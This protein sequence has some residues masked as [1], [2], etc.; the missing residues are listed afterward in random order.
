[1]ESGD[2]KLSPMLTIDPET[3]QFVGNDAEKANQ[4]LQ[5]EYR[6]GFEVP[7]IV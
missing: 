5:R 1:M 7:K 3:E 2:I 6:T 4:F